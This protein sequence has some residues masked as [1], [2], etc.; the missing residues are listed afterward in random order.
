MNNK[1][2]VKWAK[3]KLRKIVSARILPGTDLISGIEKVCSEN[4]IES[5]TFSVIGSIEK[6][7]FVLP[8]IKEGTKKGVG[9]GEPQ[10]VSGPLE[11]LSGKGFISKDKESE[12]GLFVHFHS[13]FSDAEGRIYGG[14]FLPGGNPVL[15]TLD[16]V[17]MEF[18]KISLSREEDSEIG[19]RVITPIGKSKAAK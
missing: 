15:L 4:G 19:I 18:E 3:G 10:T 13:I 7:T 17:I 11:I 14:H 2:R 16:V 6:A 12:S 8:V 5:G 9:Y 1:L